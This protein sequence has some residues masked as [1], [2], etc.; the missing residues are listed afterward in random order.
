MVELADESM[1][2]LIAAQHFQLFLS[3]LQFLQPDGSVCSPRT[4]EDALRNR[5]R[6]MENTGW[7][8]TWMAEEDWD[9]FYAGN[10]D[11][12]IY[13]DSSRAPDFGEFPR[14]PYWVEEFG[15]RISDCSRQTSQTLDDEC[16][17]IHPVFL[18]FLTGDYD[19]VRYAC[20]ID[21]LYFD[22]SDQ[23]FRLLLESRG[24]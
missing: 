22:E 8:T 11:Q 24:L 19:P 1:L 9:D 4:A 12:G 16:Q 20:L 5:Q 2:E 3:S 17:I 6:I 21:P 15:L 14:V 13:W 18:G 23:H 10:D 7:D